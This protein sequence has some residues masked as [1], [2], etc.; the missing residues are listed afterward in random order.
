PAGGQIQ[1]RLDQQ[2]KFY[3]VVIADNGPGIPASELPRLFDRFYRLQGTTSEGTGLG[4]AIA[5]SIVQAPR[6]QIQV[7]SEVGQGTCFTILL[8]LDLREG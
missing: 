2:G 8:P 6:G 1:M 7:T 4:L 5:Q 3:R